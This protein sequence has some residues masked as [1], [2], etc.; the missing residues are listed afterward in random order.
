MVD[1]ATPAPIELRAVRK[2]Y[3]RLVA[4][5]G[6]DLTVEPGTFHCLVGPN[7]SG[8][9]TLLR[10]LLG[11]TE[12]SAGEVSVP[13]V[14][15]GTAFQRPSHYEDLTVAENLEV[16]GA[17]SG[18]DPDWSDAVL[19]RLGLD[20]VSGRIA[21]D[22]SGGYSRKLDLALALCKEPAYLLLDEP[23]GDLDDVTK[24][25]LVEF[26]G[27]YRDAGHGVVVSTHNLEQFAD[28]VDRL[29]LVH[30]GRVLYDEPRE[31]FPAR[32]LQTFYVERVL[33]AVESE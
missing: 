25:R 11:L 3:G 13:D 1:D 27:E 16:F 20:V 31:S 6:V 4:V 29:T 28:H 22:L 9:T 15:L 8:K 14:S 5:D 33:S 12:P 30:E 19:E 26:L 32:D 23:L 18:A 17:L 2:R 10:M 24:R 21:G 7:G